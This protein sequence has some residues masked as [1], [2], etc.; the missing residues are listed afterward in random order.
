MS[1][2][3]LSADMVEALGVLNDM[4]L[5]VKRVIPVDPTQT[6]STHTAIL[7]GE[8]PARS[9]IV[10]NNYHRPGTPRTEVTRGLD[11]EIDAD[12]LLDV[13]RRNGKRVGALAF[14]T[15]DASS[16]RRTPDFGIRYAKNLTEPRIVQLRR[17]DFHAEWLPPTWGT[18]AGRHPSYS[19]PMRARIEWRLPQKARQ[20]VDL[21][22]Y[23][24]TDDGARNYDAF[25]VES[26][27][28]EQQLD[29]TRWFSISQ[30][31]DDGLYGS[32]SK[33]L[34]T[35]ATLDGVTVYWGP[36]NRT[37]A[38]PQPFR[39][40]LDEEA[41]FW[42]GVPDETNARSGAI[43]HATF[44]EQ[45]ERF[46]GYLTKAAGAAIAHEPFDLLLAYQPVIDQVEHPFRSD[47]PMRRAAYAAMA[48]A[49][50]ATSQRLDP[51]HDAL[52]VLGD[53]GLAPFDT[54]VRVTR[55]LAD[56]NLSDRWEAFA[57]GGSIVHFYRFGDPDDAAQLVN[58]LT[59]LKAPDG[60]PVFERVERKTAAMHPNSGDVVA[61]GYP[62]FAL[63]VGT[64][65]LF[66]SATGGQ[67]G[68]L[69][70]H[71]EYHTT[72]GARGAGIVPDNIDELPQTEIAPFVRRLL[73]WH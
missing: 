53:H 28:G 55:I 14:P 11:A 31:L 47:E 33:L 50:A 30:R 67:H 62:R 59:N 25:F 29:G 1:F 12:T 52:I 73:G 51:A 32:W 16:P 61:F 44:T 64:G 63:A 3:G 57:S 21:V 13:A 70:T 26:S 46:S 40:V 66:R 58:I 41:G 20:D 8:T 4:P 65:D 43:D 71:R 54:V 19:P 18:P 56:N 22:A 15:I 38:Y 36:V 69:S 37:D 49:V 68:G 10:A 2:D 42:P 9:G 24:L 5:R 6:S 7:T 45:L 72:L 17:A 34:K 48:R 23:D 35:D 39:Q 27:A 60:A